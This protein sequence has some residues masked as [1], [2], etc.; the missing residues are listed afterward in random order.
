MRADILAVLSHVW[1]SALV[2]WANG[3]RDFSSVMTELDR[4]SRVLI[5]PYERERRAPA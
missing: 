2:T 4:A 1:Y 5:E 3:R